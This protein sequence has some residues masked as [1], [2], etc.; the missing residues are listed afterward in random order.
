MR[1][2]KLLTTQGISPSLAESLG[3]I[4]GPS[5]IEKFESLPEHCSREQVMDL[6]NDAVIYIQEQ[7]ADVHLLS[8]DDSRHISS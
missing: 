7:K 1:Y 2:L 4:M 3:E 5:W 6:Y 8:P